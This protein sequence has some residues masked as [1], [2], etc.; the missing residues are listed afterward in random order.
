[1]WSNVKFDKYK[2]IRTAVPAWARLYKSE[3]LSWKVCDTPLCHHLQLEIGIRDVSQAGS[4]WWCFWWH[5]VHCADP[6]GGSS[7]RTRSRT[8]CQTRMALLFLSA[9][10]SVFWVSAELSISIIENP[11]VLQWPWP[12]D[13]CLDESWNEIS[14]V[15]LISCYLFVIFI[16]SLGTLK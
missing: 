14:T 6:A 3:H 16:F 12:L 11:P 9:R 5:T 15:R 4:Q 13:M 1:M 8:H 2:S 7:S 10:V